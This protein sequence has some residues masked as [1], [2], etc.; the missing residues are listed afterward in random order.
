MNSVRVHIKTLGR[1]RVFSRRGRP[2]VGSGGSRESKDHR[3]IDGVNEAAVDARPEV[4]MESASGVGR[5]EGA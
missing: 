2:S 4:P 5:G 3:S 1:V